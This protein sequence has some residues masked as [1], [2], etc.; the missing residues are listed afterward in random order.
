MI[1]VN[2]DLPESFSKSTIK[3]IPK[4]NNSIKEINDYRPITLTNFDYRIFA[5]VITNRVNFLNSY[6]FGDNQISSIK[7]KK[8]N[9]IIHLV[10]DLIFDANLKKKS[11]NITLI[12]QSKAFDLIDHRYLFKILDHM[13]LGDRIVKSIRRIYRNAST[14]L[15]INDIFSHEIII[16]R[17]IKQ[18]CPL[19]MWLYYVA[20]EDLLI[21]IDKNDSIILL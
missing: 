11:L 6:I 1:N 16:Q 13:N 9:D 20:I 3:L 17:G 14:N 5:K 21:K 19:S 12:D 4:N 10:K 2:S 18:G 7:Y 8:I 15:A